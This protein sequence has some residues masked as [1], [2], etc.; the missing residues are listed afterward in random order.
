MR[1]PSKGLNFSSKSW[2]VLFKARI[3]SLHLETDGP[4]YY[5]FPR[6]AIKLSA[7]QGR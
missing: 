7:T 1:A 4:S 2:N 3:V 6:P 5:P